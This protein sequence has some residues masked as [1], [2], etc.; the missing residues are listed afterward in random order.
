MCRTRRLPFCV[1]PF[2]LRMGCCS[3]LA[4]GFST[5]TG[6]RGRSFERHTRKYSTNGLFFFCRLAYPFSCNRMMYAAL[7]G[8]KLQNNTAICDSP[9]SSLGQE[10]T[11]PVVAIHHNARRRRFLTTLCGRF[12]HQRIPFVRNTFPWHVCFRAFGKARALGT[13]RQT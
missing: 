1:R 3:C 10:S 13:D 12:C 5:R 4:F 8:V 6:R 9:Q 7:C 11:T 2:G